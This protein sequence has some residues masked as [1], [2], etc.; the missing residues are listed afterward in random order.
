MIAVTFSN[1]TRSKIRPEP[2]IRSIN[3]DLKKYG[4]TDKLGVEL[5]IIGTRAMRSL[6]KKYRQKNYATDV[7]SFPIWPNLDTIK[8]QEGQVLLGSIVICLPIARKQAV[9]QKQSLVE[10]LNFLLAHSLQHLLGFH[11]EGD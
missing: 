3:D 5:R 7:I 2:L 1:Q 9:D 6:N 11:H 4:L 10:Q 8:R